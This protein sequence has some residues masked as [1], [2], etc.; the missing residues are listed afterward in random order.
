MCN[1]FLPHVCVCVCVSV[2][3]YMCICVRVS[4]R[5]RVYV[6]VYVY[7]CVCV[8]VGD[9]LHVVFGDRINR[10]QRMCF[11]LTNET[12]SYLYIICLLYKL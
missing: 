1:S 12:K 4:V 11:F 8:G 7:V 9:L 3:V 5:V 10:Y 2:C 6:Y